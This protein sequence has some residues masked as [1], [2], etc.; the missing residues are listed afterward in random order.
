MGFF[1]FH[2]FNHICM[3]WTTIS[4][5]HLYN[6]IFK[7]LKFFYFFIYF[8]KFLSYKFCSKI[9]IKISSWHRIKEFFCFLERDSTLFHAYD[10]FH[11]LETF[12][13]I[14]PIWICFAF[15]FSTFYESH[16]FIEPDSISWCSGDF[17]NFSYT[18]IFFFYKIFD[19]RL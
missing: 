14:L 17:C 10:S 2:L 13:I 19:R 11:S 8:G 5:S 9:I 12:F 6:R 7:T 1:L 18:H 15:T 16:L 4:F 3:L